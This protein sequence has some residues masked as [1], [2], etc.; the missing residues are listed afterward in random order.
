MAEV[1]RHL[2][3]EHK[4]LVPFI[5]LCVTCN[6]D[7]I[8]PTAWESNHNKFCTNPRKQRRGVLANEQWNALYE[9][10]R[11]RWMQAQIQAEPQ[12]QPPSETQAQDTCK[13]FTSFSIPGDY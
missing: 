5:K 2:K 12:A 7:I 6:E 1:R 13:R 10:L 9:I 8:D 11:Q 3:R 4:E